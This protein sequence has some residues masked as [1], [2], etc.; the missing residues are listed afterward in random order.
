MPLELPLRCR[1]GWV[2]GVASHV[3]PSTGFRFI[4]YCGDCRAFASM[5]GRPD[6]LDPAG[7]TDI[8]QM[9]PGRVKLTAGMDAVRCV[10]LS[11]KVLRWYAECCQTPIANSAATPR[12]PIIGLIHSFIDHKGGNRFLDEVLGPP[13][14]QIYERSAIGTLPPNAPGPPSLGV[15]A[16]RTSTMIGW[17]VRGLGSPHPF[18]HCGCPHKRKKKSSSTDELRPSGRFHA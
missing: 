8:F 14:C 11:N 16:R 18:S 9:P 3:S 2:R 6:V 13:L 15:L 1:C 4:C 7:G 12:F 17:W 10:S 5:L